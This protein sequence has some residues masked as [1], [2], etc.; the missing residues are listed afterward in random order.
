MNFYKHAHSLTLKT[1]KTCFTCAQWLDDIPEEPC[2]YFLFFITHE[3]WSDKIHVQSYV[4]Y[5]ADAGFWGK[6]ESD[7]LSSTC[8]RGLMFSQTYCSV[9]DSYSHFHLLSL[10]GVCRCSDIGMQNTEH[11]QSPP[12]P[13]LIPRCAMQGWMCE[14][15]V[16]SLNLCLP[17]RSAG[18]G[19]HC[20]G[21]IISLQMCSLEKECRCAALISAVSGGNAALPGVSVAQRRRKTSDVWLLVD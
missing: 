17:K 5:D 2:F 8:S 4:M 16:W 3:R 14:V 12:S 9:V 21:W 6:Q 19:V 7:V 18:W 10:T 20:E 15:H 13:S 1:H 11:I